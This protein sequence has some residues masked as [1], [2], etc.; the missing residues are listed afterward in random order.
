MSSIAIPAESELTG[1][2]KEA[3]D[4]VAIFAD[5]G[6][7]VIV[8]EGLQDETIAT[9]LASKGVV[10]TI[11]PVLLVKTRDQSGSGVIGTAELVVKLSVNPNQNVTSGVN[12]NIYAAKK[13]IIEALVRRA[14]HPGGEFFRAGDTVSALSGFDP[15]VWEY[16]LF[17]TKECVS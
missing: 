5:A 7:S 13:A 10:V 11:L 14:R 8:D 16:D 2:I 12:L 4:A 15:G 3:L 6:I 17:F 9:A 1:I